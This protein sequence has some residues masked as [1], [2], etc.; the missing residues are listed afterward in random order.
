M[1]THAPADELAML[2]AEISRLRTR[3]NA[4]RSQ[5]IRASEA[6]RIGRFVRVEV[7]ERSMRIF[8]HRLLPEAVREDPAFWRDRLISEVRCL[9]NEARTP[10]AWIPPDKPS[11]RTGRTAFGT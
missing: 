7:V 5:L 2:R 10:A 8:D 4:L 11:I 1:R 3:E 6:G 9:P